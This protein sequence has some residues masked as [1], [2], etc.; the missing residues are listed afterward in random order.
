L[1]QLAL[2]TANYHDF[3]DMLPGAKY[4]SATLGQ[5]IRILPYLEQT[6]LYNAADFSR[7]ALFVVNIPAQRLQ[8]VRLRHGRLV[9]MTGS[10]WDFGLGEQVFR[11]HSQ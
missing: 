9:W 3:N 4:A 10:C 1:K 7:Q 2:A 11:A 8:D 5:F 6:S